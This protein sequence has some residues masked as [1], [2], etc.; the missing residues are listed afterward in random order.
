LILTSHG[1]YELR[2][3]L[4]RDSSEVQAASGRPEADSMN[5]RF[6]PSAPA[7]PYIEAAK[8]LPAVQTVLWFDR[9][10]VTRFHTEGADAVVEISDM[11]FPQMRRD[12]PASFTYRVRLAADQ[13]V[14]SQG[15]VRPN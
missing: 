2:M 14:L 1:V 15:W 9:F 10:P 4:A 6:Y 12:H 13:K 11:R 8:R 5:Y 7:N 3:D